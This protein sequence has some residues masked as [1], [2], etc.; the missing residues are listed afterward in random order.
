MKLICC[1]F[2]EAKSILIVIAT[3]QELE[4]AMENIAQVLRMLYK[5]YLSINH[6]SFVFRSLVN[7]DC[8]SYL[9]RVGKSNGEYHP[10]TRDVV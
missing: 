6:W 10:G 2:S 1:M 8:Y 9:S 5:A 3:F 7:T 4:K